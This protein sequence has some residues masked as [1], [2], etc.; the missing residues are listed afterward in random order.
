MKIC[1]PVTEDKGTASPVSRHFGSA[2][3]FLIVDTESGAC[4]TVPNR[5]LHHSHGVCAPLSS[6]AGEGIDGM[7]VGGIGMGAMAK[8]GAAGLQ[9]F[10]SE[11]ATVEE[12]L[13]AFRAGALK[14][15][16][17]EMA[18]GRHGHGHR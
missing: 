10:L 15:M 6:L 12:T 14:I 3:L 9:V 5:N 11:H 18:C 4:R 17:P 2:P 7:V 8:L 13:A 1:I 16:S